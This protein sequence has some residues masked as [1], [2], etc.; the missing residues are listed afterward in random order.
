VDLDYAILADGVTPRADGKL[1][2]HGAA[3]DTIF[4]SNVPARHPRITL[5]VRVLLSR[6]EAENPHNL[7]V[8]LSAAD[9]AELARVSGDIEPAPEEVRNQLPAGRRF[10]IGVVLNFENVEFPEFGDYQLALQWDGNE[11]REPLRLFVQPIPSP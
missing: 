6:H 10:G 11:L 2:I 3:W 8:I 9:G 4:A 1:D 5:A 7:S